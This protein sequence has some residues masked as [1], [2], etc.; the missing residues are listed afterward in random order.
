LSRPIVIGANR[1]FPLALL[2][3]SLPLLTAVPAGNF[4]KWWPGFQAAV[5]HADAKTVAQMTRFPLSWENG[6]IRE[7][8]TEAEFVQGFDKYFTPEIRKAIAA[9]KPEVLPDGTYMLTWKARGNEY[10]LYFKPDGSGFMLDAL[11]EGPA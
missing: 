10:S 9:G 6:P 11:S 1:L 8:R 2:V 5:A 7:I 4:A 3:V